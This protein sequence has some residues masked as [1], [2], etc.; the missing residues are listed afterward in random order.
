MNE[1]MNEWMDEWMNVFIQVHKNW[2]HQIKYTKDTGEFNNIR[3]P[4][5]LKFSVNQP[6]RN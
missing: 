6:L 4:W 5:V 3:I 2:T 1:W